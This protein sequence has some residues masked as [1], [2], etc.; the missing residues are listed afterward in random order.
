MRQVPNHHKTRTEILAL[1]SLGVSLRA[2]C[3]TPGMPSASTVCG[4]CRKQPAFA[5][6]YQA[7]RRKGARA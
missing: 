4:W 3:R 6:L 2:I 5:K 1:L 7:A